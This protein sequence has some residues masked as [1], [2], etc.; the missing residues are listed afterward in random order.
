MTFIKAKGTVGKTGLEE[1]FNDVLEGVPGSEVFRVKSGGFVAD[2]ISGVPPRQGQNL[3]TSLDIALQTVGENEFTTVTGGLKGA[4]VALDVNT[5][6]VLAMANVPSYSPADR[7][8]LSGAQ[9]RNRT[10]TD[11]FE[12]GSTMKP[13]V[14][15]WALETGRVT[16]QTVIQTA[17]GRMTLTGS[18]ITDSHPHGNL[19]VSEVIQ[20][21]SNVGAVRMAMTFT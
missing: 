2:R 9:V 4:F 18:T 20:K 13:F 17:P 14:A 21:S 5:G 11:T 19:T 7:R 16:P 6:E 15:A 8:N 1:K 12:P 3:T 10:I